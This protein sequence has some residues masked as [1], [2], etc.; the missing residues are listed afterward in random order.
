[1]AREDG[2]SYN[3]EAKFFFLNTF[4]TKLTEEPAII[5]TVSGVWF[6]GII[7]FYLKTVLKSTNST[8]LDHSVS[9]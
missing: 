8:I 4:Q 9:W 5:V 1:M 3:F 6:L 2:G 7:G